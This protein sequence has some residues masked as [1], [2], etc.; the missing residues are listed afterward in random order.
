MG[1]KERDEWDARGGKG[2]KEKGSRD[3][4][5]RG[6]SGLKGEGVVGCEG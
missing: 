4:W 1:R 3:K 2:Q 6:M 5:G